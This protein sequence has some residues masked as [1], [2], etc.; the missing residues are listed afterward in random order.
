MG[1][2][3]DNEQHALLQQ[4]YGEPLSEDAKDPWN[5]TISRLLEHVS[6]RHF[7]RDDRLPDGTLNTLMAAAQSASTGSMLQSWSVVA[8]TDPDRKSRVA[9]LCGDQDFIH[10]APLFLL[11]SAD[12]GRLADA[13]D[14]HGY[15]NA[16]IAAESLG[17][18]MCYVGGAR[19]NAR[20]LAD[21]LNLPHR[22]VGL[23]GMAVGKADPAYLNSRKPRLP[24][25][26]VVHQDTWKSEDRAKRIVKYES[27]LK[28]HY[29]RQGKP[30]RPP[31]TCL[32]ADFVSSSDLDGR[33]RM[34]DVLDEQG[35]GL[36]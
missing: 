28:T 31:W 27:T 33:G 19:N 21:Y 26:E 35:F 10:Q 34:R 18:G 29:H 2:N 12:L 22:V 14:R 11:F 32:L 23:F 5:P 3:L 1:S 20:D 9:M 16:T 24:M 15:P 13:S 7:L 6:V 25:N 17:L 36:S 4:R 30:E 8:V